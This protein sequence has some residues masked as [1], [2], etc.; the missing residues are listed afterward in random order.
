VDSA[1]TY[2]TEFVASVWKTLGEMAPYLLFGFLVAGLLAFFIPRRWVESHLGGRGLWPVLKSAVFGL[3]LPLCSCSVIPVTASLRRHGAS[4]GASTAFLIATPQTGVDSLL[5][6]FSLLGPVFAVFRTVAAFISGMIGGAAVD[7]LEGHRGEPE[8]LAQCRDVC[9]DDDPPN[10]RIAGCLRYGFLNLPSDIGRPLLLGIVVAGAIAAFVPDGFFAG[11]G[12]GIGAILVLMLMG[13]PVYVCAT[14]SVPVAA[15]LVM[16]GVSPGAALAFLMTGPATNAAGIATVWRLM[17]MRTAIAYLATVAVTAFA[18][19]V[20]LDAFGGPLIAEQAQA[21][22]AMLPAWLT[23]LFAVAL[24]AVVGHAVAR[25][26][27]RRRANRGKCAHCARDDHDHDNDHAGR[28]PHEHAASAAPT[29]P[30]GADVVD[31]PA[32]EPDEGCPHCSGREH[33]AG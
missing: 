31:E 27:L 32:E 26:S 8:H 28:G 12:T 7:A 1:L 9:C 33:A 15:A 4:R 17:G 29:C 2:T 5:V 13:I 18:S 30:H 23:G 11:I 25:D 19:G 22:H 21:A 20:I 10:R 14:A 6:T 16:K 3:P 24:L